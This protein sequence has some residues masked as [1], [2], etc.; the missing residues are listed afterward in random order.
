MKP[1]ANC[2]TLLV[3][4]PQYEEEDI[5]TIYKRDHIRFGGDSDKPIGVAGLNHH[6]GNFETVTLAMDFITNTM[7]YKILESEGQ[8]L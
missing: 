3:Y 5:Y 4:L 7:K 6:V 8:L 1:K 2:I